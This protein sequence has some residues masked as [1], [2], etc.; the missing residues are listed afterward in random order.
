MDL[1]D[2]GG[3]TYDQFQLDHCK[4]NMI[5]G[6]DEHLYCFCFFFFFFFFGGGGQNKTLKFESKNFILCN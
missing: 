6:S 3:E 5:S 4:K 1:T 2:Q